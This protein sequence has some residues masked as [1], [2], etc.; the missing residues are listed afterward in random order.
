MYLSVCEPFSKEG[1][2]TGTSGR[3]HTARSCRRS[4]FAHATF[5]LVMPPIE[6]LPK[7]ERKQSK[8]EKRLAQ[9]KHRTHMAPEGTGVRALAEEQLNRRHTLI[10]LELAAAAFRTRLR[11][12]STQ[13]GS[14]V[15]YVKE[16]TA[17]AWD[18]Y[19]TTESHKREVKKN[20]KGLKQQLETL[21]AFMDRRRS[22]V[23]RRTSTA[24]AA[25]TP[26]ALQDLRGS[27]LSRFEVLRKDALRKVRGNRETADVGKASPRSFMPGRRVSLRAAAAVGSSAGAIL[28]TLRRRRTVVHALPPLST[29]TPRAKGGG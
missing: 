2:R 4:P 13:G 26:E 18:E 11:R 16:S 29:G 21:S 25:P 5:A 20:R 9:E 24:K 22:S 14:G 23:M 7:I 28:A 17:R 3:E 19:V 15:A 10:Q 6:A 1:K 12:T 8:R 27:E